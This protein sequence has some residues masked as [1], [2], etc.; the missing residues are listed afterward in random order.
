MLLTLFQL[1]PLALFA[2]YANG[3]NII[4]PSAFVDPDYV[5]AK[6]YGNHTL[7]A[8]QTIASWANLLAARGPWSTLHSSALVFFAPLCSVSRRNQQ[9]YGSSFGH[10]TRLH[11]S[12]SLV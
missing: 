11:Q 1:I 4:Y 2:S 10:K 12:G 5:L 6:N 9:D 3:Q 8:Q 7:A